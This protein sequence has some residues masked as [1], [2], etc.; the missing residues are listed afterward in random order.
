MTIG[1]WAPRGRPRTRHRCPVL[2]ARSTIADLWGNDEHT[3]NGLYRQREAGLLGVEPGPK[4]GV[5]M[6][7][8]AGRSIEADIGDDGSIRLFVGRRGGVSSVSAE[9]LP[10]SV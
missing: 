8:P 10:I 3:L 2:P 6:W 7:N 1:S 5:R 4:A 9:D